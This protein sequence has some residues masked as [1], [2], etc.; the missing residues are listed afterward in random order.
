M[1]L[2]NYYIELKAKIDE[3]ELAKQES[4]Q[5]VQN[6]DIEKSNLEKQIE[7]LRREIQAIK[8]AEDKLTETIHIWV[9]HFSLH[10]KF[11]SLLAFITQENK[12]QLYFSKRTKQSKLQY[13][14]TTNEKK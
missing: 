1:I 10:Q 7:N 14:Y 8:E 13:K 2:E 3:L 6:L 4:D 5:K 9:N 12:M 11:K